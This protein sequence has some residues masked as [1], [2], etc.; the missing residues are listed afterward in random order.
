MKFLLTI[1]STLCV[2]LLTGCAN[3][4]EPLVPV[5]M[6]PSGLPELTHQGGMRSGGRLVSTT[7]RGATI[8]LTH[9]E[10]A[11]IVEEY[12]GGGVFIPGSYMGITFGNNGRMQVEITFDE[13]I[14]E[15]I[16]RIDPLPDVPVTDRINPIPGAEVTVQFDHAYRVLTQQLLERQTTELDIIAGATISSHAI[17][18]A[19]NDALRHA[20]R[21]IV[22][23][24]RENTALTGQGQFTPGVYSAAALGRNDYVEVVLHLNET[25]IYRVDIYHRE[26]PEHAHIPIEQ[27]ADNI[28]NFQGN[29]DIIAGATRSSVA[30]MASIEHILEMA[31]QP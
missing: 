25:T 12:E 20:V 13:S 3:T 27:M 24:S 26:T 22:I 19:F 28:L 21:E 23:V 14:I 15:S 1:I 18:H 2:L 8:D 7:I 30:I 31:T 6:S 10:F 4:Y 5:Q 17:I 11:S 29:V 16:V 9:G